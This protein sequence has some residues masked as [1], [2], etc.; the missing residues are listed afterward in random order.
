MNH[1][2]H[3]YRSSTI[4]YLILLAGLLQHSSS[5]T[6]NNKLS[7][8]QEKLQRKTSNSSLGSTA[9]NSSSSTLHLKRRG[10]VFYPIGYG[11]DPSGSIDSSDAI[12][13]AINDAFRLQKH[14]RRQLLPGIQDLGGIVLDLQGGNFLISKPIQLPSGRG[15][16]VVRSG[17][18]R[19]T[20]DFPGNR[21]LIE[22][23]STNSQQKPGKGS[24]YEGIT[25]R[26]ILFD[27]TYRGGGI[28]VVDSVRIRIDHC[29]FLHFTTQGILVIKGHETF[30]SN[31]FLGQ[32]PTVGGDRD[33]IRYSGTAVDIDSNDNALTNVAIFSAAVGVV[34]RSEANTVTAVHCYNKANVYGGVGIV[35]KPEASLTRITGCYMDFT[36]VVIED[37]DQVRVSDGLFIGGANVV[38][39]SIRGSISGL[40]VE[41]NMFRGYEGRGNSIVELD[42]NFT[43]V[44][45]VVVDRNNVKDMVLKS[46]AGKVTVAGYG[47]R[48]VADFSRVLIFPDRISHFQYA[49]HVRGGG[50][51]ENVTHW[52]S[53][54]SGNAVVVQS[55][56]VVNAVVSVVVDQYNVVDGN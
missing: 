23:W 35:V 25:F 18:F 51:G 13:R 1:H 7:E 26:D 29:F 32:N 12:L 31:C 40:N 5:Y 10:K 28:R 4:L 39:K 37:P 48:W 22:L 21:H 56:A 47:S 3:Q 36:D 42:G 55:N 53:G 50:G 9:W 17:T 30:V 43:A 20:N 11:A 19:A 49:F 8:F 15:N 34:L 14:H 27:S 2:H 33:E 41:G 54:V 38:V 44:D 16:F 6:T 46:T 52:V 45:Q 24:Y